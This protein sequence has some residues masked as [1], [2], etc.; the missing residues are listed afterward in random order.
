M[1][2]YSENRSIL[3]EEKDLSIEQLRRTKDEDEIFAL[4]QY[5]RLI[6]QILDCN[7]SYSSSFIE[8]WTLFR[9][10]FRCDYQTRKY[11][12]EFADS[13]LNEQHYQY[14]RY[15][16]GE[17]SHIMDITKDLEP[18]KQVYNRLSDDKFLDIVREFMSLLGLEELLREFVEERKI[19]N[20][21]RTYLDDEV[22][23]FLHN[24]IKADGFVCIK[25]FQNTIYCMSTLV[26]ELG[27]VYDFRQ[28]FSSIGSR[29]AY[30][31][32]SLF[33]ESIP[34]CFERLL[35][36]FLIENTLYKEEGKKL[37]HDIEYQTYKNAFLSYLY[38]MSEPDFLKNHITTTIR[39]LKLGEEVKRE[40]K[41]NLQLKELLKENQNFSLGEGG[42]YAYGYIISLYLADIIHKDGYSLEGLEPFLK[43]RESAFDLSLLGDYHI[44][45][46]SFIL[47]RQK[48]KQ[49]LKK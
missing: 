7:S 46:D 10:F 17:V 25:K 14:H 9:H 21:T 18:A 36:V 47:L 23:F 20:Y 22:G 33:S 32:M 16:L 37:L 28:E 49:L 15:L 3:K 24:S 13:F 30:L 2:L 27:H 8:R 19:V 42:K 45:P 39:G 44:N 5:C 43:K 4:V 26:H 1:N 34:F 38:S 35:A 11:E 6:N 12:K 41:D 40:N 48:E 31:Y 29:N